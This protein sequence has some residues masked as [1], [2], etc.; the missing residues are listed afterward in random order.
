MKS[1]AFG[2]FFAVVGLLGVSHWMSSSTTSAAISPVGPDRDLGIVFEN[3]GRFLCGSDKIR[4]CY[5]GIP[6]ISQ[7]QEICGQ[8]TPTRNFIVN[9]LRA[10]G[11]AKCGFC[12]SE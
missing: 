1:F 2:F 3:C 6:L 9:S 7:E 8:D 10:V 11:R 4:Y 5:Y 12:D